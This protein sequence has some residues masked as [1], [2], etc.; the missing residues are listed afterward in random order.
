MPAT[1]G[2]QPLALTP[3]RQKHGVV[4]GPRGAVPQKLAPEIPPH[5][6]VPPVRGVVPP[7]QGAEFSPH[8][9]A[10]PV[11]AR[12][13]LPHGGERERLEVVR[14][15]LGPVDEPEP[16]ADQKHGTSRGL[17]EGEEDCPDLRFEENTGR[18]RRCRR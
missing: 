18:Y 3:V 10:R 11:Q 1:S 17:Q 5:A 9:P 14:R 8:A 2:L 15:R 6:P 13:F 16:L 12:E 7:V 4:H